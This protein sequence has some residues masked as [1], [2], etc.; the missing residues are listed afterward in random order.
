VE[1]RPLDDSDS[2]LVERARSGDVAAY[3]AIVRRYQAVA[4]R[5][6]YTIVGSAEDAEDATQE[7]FVRAY[8]AIHRFRAGAPL[9]PWLLTIIT[10]AARSHRTAAVRRPALELDWSAVVARAD[11]APA[12]EAAAL[13]REQQRELLAA[14]DALRDDD[15]QVIIS[16]YFL[17]LSETET[18][19]VLGCAQ[20]TVK[21]RLSRSLSRLRQ[22]W[23]SSATTANRTDHE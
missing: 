14:V 10:N 15:R 8:R 11:S 5:V 1:V 19:A 9:R 6:A 22:Q 13:S 21:S 18:A 20:G 23:Q 3:E 17:G 2:G 12:P 7:G 4:F 16:R